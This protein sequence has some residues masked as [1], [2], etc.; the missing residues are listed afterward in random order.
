MTDQILCCND[1][2]PPE[3][4]ELYK[5]YGVVTPTEGKLYTI[6]KIIKTLKGIGILLNELHNPDVPII[7][8]FGRI[9]GTAEPSWGLFRFVNLDQS[10]ITEEEALQL[11]R[12]NKQEKILVKP[13][14]S[15]KYETLQILI[16][17]NYD[18]FTII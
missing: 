15:D 5:K 8:P 12:A 7:H 9:K 13:L 6:R 17:Q 3:F 14:K 11:L 4:I 18:I 16:Q 1:K 2:F 10:E